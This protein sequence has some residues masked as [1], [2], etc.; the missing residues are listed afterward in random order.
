[1]IVG[2]IT[3]FETMSDHVSLCV[4]DQNLHVRSEDHDETT[5]FGLHAQIQVHPH[6]MDLPCRPLS[7]SCSVVL[8][9]LHLMS[10]TLSVSIGIYSWTLVDAFG[11][12]HVWDHQCRLPTPVMEHIHSTHPVRLTLSCTDLLLY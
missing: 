10:G 5:L 6:V 11:R 3:C 8:R 12:T 7:V 4:R 2:A 1:M 9:T